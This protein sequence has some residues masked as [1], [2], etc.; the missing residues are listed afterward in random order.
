MLHPYAQIEILHTIQTE[1]RQALLKL[2]QQQQKRPTFIARML[3]TT[4]RALIHAGNGL[5]QRV[6]PRFNS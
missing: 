3:H 2:R 1:K 5:Q 4:G 6:E